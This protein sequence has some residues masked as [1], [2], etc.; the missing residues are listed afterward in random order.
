MSNDNFA[1]PKM[2]RCPVIGDDDDDKHTIPTNVSLDTLL[3]LHRIAVIMNLLDEDEEVT[4]DD[5]TD[6][7]HQT[8]K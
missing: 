3:N 8:N 6:E 7:G 1:V 4:D 5:K 2:S